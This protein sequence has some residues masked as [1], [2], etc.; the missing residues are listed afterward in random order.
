[1]ECR[2]RGADRRLWVRPALDR[3]SLRFYVSNVIKVYVAP[4]WG[5]RTRG[6]AQ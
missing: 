3:G 5:G 4:V 6:T 1:M 2:P